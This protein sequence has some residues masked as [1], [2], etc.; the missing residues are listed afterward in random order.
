MQQRRNRGSGV[1]RVG[2]PA[3]MERVAPRTRARRA[4]LPVAALLSASLL[5]SI[6]C[7]A[8]A[9]CVG[10]IGDGGAV[11]TGPSPEIAAQV[12]VSGARR[13]SAVEYRSAVFDL[14]GVDVSDAALVL[15]TDER[16]PFDND[17]TKQ[18]ASQALI[19]GVELLAGEIAAEVTSDPGLRGAVVPCTPQSVAD[20]ACFREFVTVF[21]RRALRRPLGDDEVEAFTTA[22]L[23]HAVTDD[24][25]WTAV[26][27][28]LRAF[29]QHPSFLYRAE[30]GS[31]VAGQPELESLDDFAVAS[32]ISFLLWGTTPPDFLLDAAAA[33]E[34]RDEARLRELAELMLADERA[35]ARL[36]R[37][38]AMWLAYEELS[39][40]SSLAVDMVRETE[41]LLSRHILEER[42]P[43]TSLLRASETFVTPALATHYGLEAPAGGSAAWVSYGDSGRQGLLSHGSFLSAVSKFGDTSPTQR[44]LLIQTR[45]FCQTINHPPPELMVN[46]DM[47]PEGPDP[48]ACKSQRYD[49]WK[50]DGCASCHTLMDPV[51]FGLENYDAMGAYRETEPN[52][53]DCPIEGVG[54]LVGFGEFRG[55]AELA[56]LMISAGDVD[57]CVARTLYR[58][59]VGRFALDRH[60][61]ALVARLVEAADLGE[62]LR[63]DRVISEYVSSEPF[64]M[65]RQEVIG[66]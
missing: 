60:D 11:S 1:D 19:D 12:A 16:T 41:A 23:P 33:G 54:S 37:F 25:F 36:S 13:L 38:H 30:I 15:P 64:R 59:A 17:Y 40:G 57:A 63:I 34:L 31:P 61:E 24:D 48:N 3:T 51:G 32:R 18:T 21:G 47:P 35:L 4:R 56:E 20:E 45:L 65:R 10:E 58:Y 55:P 66:E 42:L 9:G 53:P 26:D 6:A 29:F 7:G 49:M 52:R 8:L 43:W 5:T 39:A 14:V 46:I 50:T 22:F 2:C 27:S 62:G 28:A 44:G